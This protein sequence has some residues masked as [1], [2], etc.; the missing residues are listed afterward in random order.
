MTWLARL[1]DSYI[2]LRGLR[3]WWPRASVEERCLAVSIHAAEKRSAL[4]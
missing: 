1:V 3:Y 2:K 4:R